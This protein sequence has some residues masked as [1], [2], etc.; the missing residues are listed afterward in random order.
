MPSFLI[1][2]L[3]ILGIIAAIF[4]AG[5][6]KGNQ[7][8]TADFE[9]L[10][11]AQKAQIAQLEIDAQKET[12]R[13]VTKYI[14]RVQTVYVQGETIIKEVPIY[15]PSDTPDLPAGFRVLHDAAASGELPD[16][17]RIADAAPVPAQDAARTVIGNYTT[18]RATAEQLIALQDWI[19]GVSK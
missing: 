4:A 18:C 1:K 14:D 15:V 13:V 11:N 17:S 16:P 9:A 6:W 8:A 10:V 3:A 2:P 19:S 12:I 7:S 5:W